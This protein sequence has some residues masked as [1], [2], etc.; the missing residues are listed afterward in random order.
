MK[1]LTMSIVIMLAGLNVTGQVIVFTMKNANITETEIREVLKIYPE[2]LIKSYLDT[3][4]VI[5]DS[6]ACGRA[7]IDKIVLSGDCR[8]SFLKEVIHHELSSV[9]LNRYDIYVRKVADEMMRKFIDWNGDEYAYTNKSDMSAIDLNSEMAN[10]FYGL[11]YAQ[12]GFENDFNV[13][14]Q[15][16]FS[17]GSDLISHINARPNAVITKKVKEVI[18]FYYILDSKFTETFFERISLQN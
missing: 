9:F 11:K 17:H 13:I 18:R 5:E 12:Q 6:R 10:Y 16:L 8:N 14:A 15:Y 4:D 7:Y 3:I 2:E 1:Q